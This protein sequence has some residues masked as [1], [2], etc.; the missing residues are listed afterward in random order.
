M[1]KMVKNFNVN[2]FLNIVFKVMLL[3]IP[4]YSKA[5]KKWR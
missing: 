2:K 5:N 4:N 3:K 1:L